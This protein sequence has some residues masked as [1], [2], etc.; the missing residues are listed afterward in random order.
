MFA[1]LIEKLQR[2]QDLSVEE[3]AAAMDE[4]MEG[5]A[6]PAQ[7]AG[8]LIA[9]G[10]EGGAAGGDRRPGAD[11][12]RARDEAVAPLRRRVRYLRHRRRSRPHVQRLDDRGAG[13]RRVRRAGREARQSIG[14]EPLR[15]RRPVR[16]ARRQHR[17]RAGGRRTLPRRSRHRVLLR[18]D[19]SPVDAARGAD[20]HGPRR[21]HGVQPA[22]AVDESRRRG[23]PAGRRARARS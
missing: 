2:R 5:R 10:D 3:A 8:L 4:I 15:Q 12:A 20:A 16:G 21:P 19:V 7:I 1:T 6:Q 17:G 22:R 23:A 18:A 9:P 13:R 14:V 11:H